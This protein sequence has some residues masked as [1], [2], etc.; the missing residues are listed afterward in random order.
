MH[1]VAAEQLMRETIRDFVR[2]SLNNNDD[3]RL[4]NL[5]FQPD[6]LRFSLPVAKPNVD[7][8]TQ[9]SGHEGPTKRQRSSSSVYSERGDP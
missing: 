3:V 9:P 6:L 2:T 7:V 5:E 1:T 8:A 4:V